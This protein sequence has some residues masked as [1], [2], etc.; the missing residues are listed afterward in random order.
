MWSGA[1][2]SPIV[3]VPNF[4]SIKGLA[5]PQERWW[6]WLPEH[7]LVLV[8]VWLPHL[9]TSLAVALHFIVLPPV[10][11]FKQLLPFHVSVEKP[12]RKEDVVRFSGP[13]QD[14]I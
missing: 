9:A 4:V 1:L 3:E 12:K 8:V 10:L 5:S 2:R 11:V 14:V 7:A 13:A 6:L